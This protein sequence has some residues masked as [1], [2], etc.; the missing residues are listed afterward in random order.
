MEKR[1]IRILQVIPD[2]DYGGAQRQFVDIVSSIDPLRF[3]VQ[4]VVLDRIGELGCDLEL[5]VS[6]VGRSRKMDP[7]ALQKL[8]KIIRTFRPEIVH[9]WLFIAH[10]YTRVAC[11]LLPGPKHVASER[12]MDLKTAYFSKLDRFLKKLVLLGSTPLSTLVLANSEALRQHLKDV[13]VSPRRIRVIRNGLNL[14]R[15]AKYTGRSARQAFGIQ[16]HL[17]V[18]GI[19]ARIDRDKDLA[20]FLRMGSILQQRGS[21][22]HL[23]VIGDGDALYQQ[24]LEYLARQLKIDEITTFTG[25]RDDVSDLLRGLDV[26]VLSSTMES[27]PNTLMEGM[28]CGLPVVATCVGGVPELVV[29][30]ETGFLTQP[31]SDS[32]LAS[33]VQQLLSSDELRMRMGQAGRKRVEDYFSLRSVLKSLESLYVDMVR[34]R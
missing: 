32:E 3:D 18:I 1:R 13:G 29:D 7:A 9:S 14:D 2:L 12:G 21:P 11:R 5:P 10:Q 34:N 31:G 4:V 30:G 22:V 8:F 15:F 6:C 17:R 25:Y 26:I 24:E 33:R 16:D 27:F 20:T 23:L 28:A 19:V